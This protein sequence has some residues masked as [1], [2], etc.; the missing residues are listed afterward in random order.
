[1]VRKLSQTSPFNE[2][3]F[4]NFFR[5]R[6]SHVTPYWFK[7][8]YLFRIRFVEGIIN[9]FQE[10][11]RKVNRLYRVTNHSF[12][13]G[14]LKRLKIKDLGVFLSNSL[15][16][17]FINLYILYSRCLHNMRIILWYSWYKNDSNKIDIY[18]HKERKCLF[19]PNI[20][21]PNATKT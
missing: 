3:Y 18:W 14:G 7:I 5:G 19:E 1:M 11:T 12:A 2:I 8:G 15:K 13:L 17:C 16:D 6:E 20:S 9:Y 10:W 21:N 4:W